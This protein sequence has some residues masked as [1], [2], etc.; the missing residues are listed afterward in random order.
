GGIQSFTIR[1][2]ATA[3]ITATPPG[4]CIY[5]LHP[6]MDGAFTITGSASVTAACGIFINSN[7]ASAY[8]QTGTSHVTSSTILVNGGTAISNNAVVSPTPTIH[9]GP[10]SDPLTALAMPTF[11]GCAHPAPAGNTYYPGVYCG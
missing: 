5:V 10:V 8:T 1:A 9:A 6:T 11:S 2:A 3:G 4:A 7:S